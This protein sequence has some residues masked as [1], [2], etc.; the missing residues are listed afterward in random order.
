MPKLC[1]TEINEKIINNEKIRGIQ[2][3][4]LKFLRRQDYFDS[5]AF[6]SKLTR[7]EKVKYAMFIKHERSNL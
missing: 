6:A 1:F 5:K 4:Q 2:W 7:E 3:S